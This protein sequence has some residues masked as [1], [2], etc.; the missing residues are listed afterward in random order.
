M[1]NIFLIHGA[2]GN[3]DENWFPWLSSE[4]KNLGCSIIAP[5]FPTPEN[6]NLSSWID[7]F[8]KYEGSLENSIVIGHSIGV[9]F[10]LNVIE[11]S[12]KKIKAAF[13]V[14][15]FTGLLNDKRFDEINRTFS[16]RKFDWKKIK[17]NCKKFYVFHSDNDPYVPIEKANDLA[18]NLST[19][20]IMV[21]NA[22]HF[23]TKSG[24]T[25]F[26]KLLNNIKKEL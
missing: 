14:S 11:S 20:V 6:Q 8:K 5:K 12:E 16:D 1:T 2:Y 22:G 18:E 4:L 25:K 24:Y 23:N 19:N 17:K 9:A 21:K 15:G 10:L 13:F 26:E 7:V 3:P